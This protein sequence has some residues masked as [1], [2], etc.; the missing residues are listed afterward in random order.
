MPTADIGFCICGMTPLARLIDGCTVGGPI[1][2]LVLGIN[3][4]PHK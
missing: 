3:D 4:D 1:P 2:L